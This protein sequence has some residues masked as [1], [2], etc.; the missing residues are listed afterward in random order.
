M[1]IVVCD[2]Q[3]EDVATQSIVWKNINAFM[4]RHGVQSVN[5]KGFMADSAQ[6]NW[7]DVRIIY[8]SGDATEKKVDKKRT[9]LFH[10]T[11]SL[12]KHTKADIR[13]YL[14]SQH[15]Q[16]CQQYKDAKSMAEAETKYL[17]IQAW[18]LSSGAASEQSLPRLELWLAFWHFRYRQWGG[19]MELVSPLFSSTYFLC[20]IVHTTSTCIPSLR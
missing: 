17:A 10:W 3:L 12:E 14:Q 5:F 7:N 20:I 2:M 6:T 18:W 4:A 9:C 1:T 16:L 15:Q 8:E 13:Q 19:F 11:Q